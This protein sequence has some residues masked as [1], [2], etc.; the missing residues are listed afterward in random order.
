MMFGLRRSRL[1]MGSVLGAVFVIAVSAPAPAQPT[2]HASVGEDT[3]TTRAFTDALAYR[4]QF[5]RMFDFLSDDPAH[6]VALMVTGG[7][8]EARAVLGLEMSESEWAEVRRREEV[9]ARAIDVK[10]MVT[11]LPLDAVSE[12]EESPYRRSSMGPLFAGVW[13]DQMDGGRL[14]LA[15]TDASALDQ[16]SLF[17]LLPRGGEDL[18]VIEQRYSLDEL[19]AW[20]D[21]I[22]S[23]LVE[24][25]IHASI[26]FNYSDEGVR[27]RLSLYPASHDA[28]LTDLLASVPAGEVLVEYAEAAPELLNLPASSHNEA[29]QQAGLQVGIHW[30]STSKLCTWGISGHTDT[31]AYVVTAGHCTTGYGTSISG[32]GL[33]YVTQNRN[34]AFVISTQ[35][36]A[37]TYA[38]LYDSAATFD[39]ARISAPYADTN[40]YHGTPTNP[41]AHCVHPITSRLSLYGHTV[42]QI[43]CASLGLT[44]D[45]HCGTVVDT[46]W[47]G[48]IEGHY[49]VNRVKVDEFEA[50]HGDS[51]S[52]MVRYNKLHGLL[53]GGVPGQYILFE[54]AYWVKAYIGASSFDF[55][56]VPSGSWWASCP[57]VYS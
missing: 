57:V 19:R 28:D 53:T 23:Y 12:S 35:P 29:D 51:G 37:F 33:R 52:G 30:P 3:S 42:G 32:W 8:D 14:K 4:L 18:L 9:L 1:V 20:R 41:N 21:T 38:R 48:E 34:S 49:T 54:Q 24:H 40:C 36:S 2:A 15:V 7:D 56:C 6:I 10:R 39:H 43:V 47:T 13:Q 44:N 46:D 5:R 11:G 22:H 17:A 31:Y 16:G 55:N 25:S 45:Y 27:L 26:G 50:D